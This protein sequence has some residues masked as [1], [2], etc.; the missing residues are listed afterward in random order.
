MG[1]LETRLKED[2]ALRDA[3]RQIV[4]ADLAL[5]KGD[6][7]DRSIAKRAADE[8]S[9]T[10]LSLADRALGYATANPLLVSGGLIAALLL[11]FRGTLV[12]LLFGFFTAD[13][14]DEDDDHERPE[15]SSRYDR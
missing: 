7:H 9:E 5:V 4:E 8:V 11:L 14:E 2:K 13:E 6:T 3:A 12:E 10:S 15:P 1:D